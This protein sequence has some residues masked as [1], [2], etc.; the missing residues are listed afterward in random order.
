MN[1]KQLKKMLEKLSKEELEKDL[2]VVANDRYLSGVGEAKKSRE[3]LFYDGSDDPC[4]LKNLTEMKEEYD[5][6]EIE[7]MEVVL[8]RGEFFIE[9]P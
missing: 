4:Q 5:S 1:L 8:N 6:E 2:I 3:K 9:L 7:G